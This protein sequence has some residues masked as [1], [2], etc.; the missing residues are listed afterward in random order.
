MKNFYHENKAKGLPIPKILG[1]TASPVMRSNPASVSK[2][3]QT[4]DSIC[5]TPKK[6][7]AE[8]RLHVKLPALLQAYFETPLPL[9]ITSLTSLAQAYR[10]MKIT[11]D[12]YYL[13]LK[14]E[15]SE[16]AQ[17]SLEKL[18]LSQKT[19]SRD[20][21]K[22]FLIIAQRIGEEL[23]EWAADYYVDQVV[24]KVL[25][26]FHDVHDQFGSEDVLWAE[27]QYIAK[28]LQNVKMAHP[29]A[30]ISVSSVSDKVTKLIDILEGE[31]G[32]AAG[33]IFV[34][35]MPQARF[36][37]L[38]KIRNSANLHVQERATASMLA[39]LL[40]YHPRTQDK[41][42]VGTVVGTSNH[43]KRTQSISELLDVSSSEDALSRFRNRELDLVIAT[44][45]L[46]EGL[47]VP[48]C[49]L[50]VCFEKPANLKSFG[51]YFV[52]SVRGL[53]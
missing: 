9:A 51:K 27:K 39:K 25:S 44:S 31:S 52:L 49:N 34:K 20:Q 36:G 35:V 22:S 53:G 28:T 7:R 41:F 43:S 29:I 38:V 11:E 33:I 4:L 50:V 42:R 3:E 45:V 21:I 17:R 23:G 14:K 13:S 8:L 19:T 10:G 18:I 16:R 15:K 40:V 46:E 1:L 26:T 32:R 12:P 48:E 6:H 5:R 30:K 2:I 47:D 24:S 37:N